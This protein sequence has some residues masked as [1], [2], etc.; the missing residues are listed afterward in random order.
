[1]KP[2]YKNNVT[3]KRKAAGITQTQLAK[4]SGTSCQYIQYI[5]YGYNAPTVYLAKKIAKV[6]KSNVEEV[7][8][9]ADEQPQN[10]ESE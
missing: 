1:M 7:F 8:P 2:K 3:E 5:E 6:L 4:E 9:E 10:K